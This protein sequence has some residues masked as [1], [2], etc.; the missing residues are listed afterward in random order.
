MSRP[1]SVTLRAKQVIAYLTW[2]MNHPWIPK[3]RWVTAIARMK[4]VKVPVPFC[5]KSRT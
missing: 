5:A 4:W 1:Q 3:R 2:S